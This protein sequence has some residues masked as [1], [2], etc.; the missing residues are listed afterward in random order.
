MTVSTATRAIRRG[1]VRAAERVDMHALM[2]TSAKMHAS[3]PSLA[4]ITSS[5]TAQPWPLSAALDTTSPLAR[6]V[7]ATLFEQIVTGAR[8]PGDLLTE[9]EIAAAAGVSRTPAR[10]ALLQL[11]AVGLVRLMPKKGAVV[12]QIESEQARDLLAVRAMF[13][14]AAVRRLSFQPERAGALRD[15]LNARLGEQLGALQAGD[16]LRFAAAD[17]AFHARIIGES[18]NQV[19]SETFAQLGPRLARLAYRAT[20]R[21]ADALERLHAEHAQLIELACAGRAAEFEAALATHIHDARGG[22]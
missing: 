17:F 6:R 21:T 12:T 19:I 20:T 18:G 15:D 5:A 16:L 4:P 10:E 22:A 1:R 8:A 3:M 7:V 2:H 9:L 14:T 13:E 11:E